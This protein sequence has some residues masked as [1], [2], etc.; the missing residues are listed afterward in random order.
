MQAVAL[1][2]DVKGSRDYPSKEALLQG[3]R[4]LA[5]DLNTAFPLS[6]VP[7]QIK[8]GDSLLAVFADYPVSYPVIL[9]LLNQELPGYIGIGFGQ[10]ETISTTRAEEANGSA[11]IHAFEAQELAKT[12][13]S[14]I[15]FAGPPYLPTALL[16][17][18]LEMLYPA[19]FGKTD[20][21]IELHR[22]M[23]RYPD[24]TYEE[25]GLKMGFKE[26][27]ARVNVAKLVSRSQ[28]KQR[29]RLEAA[30]TQAL[31]Q[32]QVWEAIR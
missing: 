16:N 32:F 25:I 3:L 6:I 24:D 2:F 20:R 4:V 14:R 15:A 12:L 1:S 21:Q 27:D 13:P 7:F 28:R 30:L 22:L 10:Y 23:D 18:Y 19:Y 5:N 17:G 26:Q 11:I 9:H 31:E 29:K 8:S